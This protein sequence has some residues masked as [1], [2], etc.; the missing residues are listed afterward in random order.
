MTTRKKWEEFRGTGLLLVIN[1][2]LHL[3]GWC[4]VF[5]IKGEGLVDV[6]PARCKFRGF[7]DEDITDSYAK[8]AK[9]C[10]ENIEEIYKE[11]TS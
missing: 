10:K 6:Y 7:G 4:I 3:F 8:V 9:Y 11:A 1:Q 2:I 5:D